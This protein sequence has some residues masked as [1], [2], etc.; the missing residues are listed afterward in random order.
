MKDKGGTER[1]VVEIGQSK[2]SRERGKKVLIEVIL[3]YRNQRED[4]TEVRRDHICVD[5]NRLGKR[6][7]VQTPMCGGR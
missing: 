2:G 1:G 3:N 4:D 7:P 6:T 5:N